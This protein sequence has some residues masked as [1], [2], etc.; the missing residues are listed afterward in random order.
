MVLGLPWLDDEH[1]SLLFGTTRVFAVMDGTP[2][3]TQIEERRPHSLLMS[4]DKI[5]NLMRK[6]RRNKGSNAEFY[7][8]DISLAT[9]KEAEYHTREK[10]QNSMKASGRY[11]A[12]TSR[13]YLV[14]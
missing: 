8:I 10:L 14:S 6:T 1:A 11:T 13:S 3:E 5:Q 4:S 7:V 12:M 2:L 9:K